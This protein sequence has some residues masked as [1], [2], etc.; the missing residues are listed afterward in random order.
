M[1]E[2]RT[3][4]AYLAEDPRLVR[5]NDGQAFAAFKVLENKRYKDPDTNEWKDAK[6]TAYDVTV[7]NAKLRDNVLA[8]LEKGQRVTVQGKYVPKPWTDKHGQNRIDHKLY[9]T[10]V[11]ASYM[12]EPQGRGGIA[13]GREQNIGAD[14]GADVQVQSNMPGWGQ[15][16]AA[17]QAPGFT[18]QGVGMTPNQVA[19]PMPTHAPNAPGADP[20]LGR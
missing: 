9:A 7:D 13:A 12:H 8:S 20:G 19:P 17:V 3:I 14:H 16:P 1:A 10:D 5:T 11:A 18:S 15:N 6:A 4:T 2:K